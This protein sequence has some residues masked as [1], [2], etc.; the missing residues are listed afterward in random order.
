MNAYPMDYDYARAATDLEL[1]MWIRFHY[2][3]WKKNPVIPQIDSSK[4]VIK[5]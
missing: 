1:K 3:E 2:R 5:K 4:A